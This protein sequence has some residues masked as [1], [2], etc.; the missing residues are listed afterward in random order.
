MRITS[1]MMNDNSLYNINNNKAYQ[2]KLNTQMATQKKFNDPSDDPI[3]A[4]RSLRFRSSLAEINQYLERNV[5]D[6]VSWVDSSQTAIDTALD[7]MRSLK[8]EYVAGANG[9]KKTT[10]DRKVYLKNMR[11]LQE[12]YYA[13]GNST[14]EDRY[15][16]TGYRTGDALTFTADN[17]KVRQAAL[18]NE[19]DDP[20]K[21]QGI[22]ENFDADDIEDYAYT[23]KKNSGGTPEASGLTNSDIT[24]LSSVNETD[25][26]N[27]KQYRLRLAYKNIEGDANKDK[28][29]KYGD[30]D[31]NTFTS[32]KLELRKKDG[33]ISS[34]YSV[35]V[36]ENDYEANLEEGTAKVYLNKTTGNLIFNSKVREELVKTDHYT[37]TYD[38]NFTAS[39]VGELKPEHYFYCTDTALGSGNKITYEEYAQQIDCTI[40]NSQH[41]KINTNAQD[42]FMPD[43]GRDLDELEDALNAV[44]AAQAKV[45]TLKKMQEDKVKYPEG[46]EDAQKIE[47]M[48]AAAEKELD[49]DTAKVE[50]IFSKGITKAQS[51]FDKVNLAGTTNGTV[52]QRLTLVQNR[53][54][55]NQFT[56]KAQASDNE[57]I[58]L[59]SLAVEVSEAS[60]SYNAALMVTGKISQ[61]SLVNYI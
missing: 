55:D 47:K 41:V 32:Y 42:A 5:S 49:Y 9:D 17:M 12:E 57:N 24:S 51:Y 3:S 44:D 1:K 23:Y 25:I 54:T 11:S 46:S 58:E 18:G 40:G 7:L 60:L 8:S 37:F 30:A 13:V 4:I 48:L 38:K 29:Y 10:E 50:E 45:D 61:Q 22:V 2:D 39:D 34:S 56:V 26:V 59:S 43:I 16:F 35:E 19:K 27:N 14:N 28:E 36:I 53:L 31:N 6:A 20:F 33:S 52:A 15:M 21:Y